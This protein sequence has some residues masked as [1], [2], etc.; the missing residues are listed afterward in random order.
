MNIFVP[1]LGMKKML[2][3]EQFAGARRSRWSTAGP[4]H[5]SLEC[6]K[7]CMISGCHDQSIWFKKNLQLDFHRLG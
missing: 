4:G 2:N 3:V 6:V 5:E 7:E 1:F